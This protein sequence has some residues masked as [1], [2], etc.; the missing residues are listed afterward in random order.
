MKI[1]IKF[2]RRSANSRRHVYNDRPH[3]GDVYEEFKET[4]IK[5]G[6]MR[7]DGS[8][9]KKRL[10]QRATGRKFRFLDRITPE[11]LE[12]SLNEFYRCRHLLCLND[13]KDFTILRLG[14]V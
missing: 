12:D 10:S 4:W 2:Y 11:G 1:T 13:P 5:I 9:P 8:V 3:R 6:E 14:K 7:S